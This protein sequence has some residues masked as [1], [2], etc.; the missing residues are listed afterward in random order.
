VWAINELVKGAL[1]CEQSRPRF[2]YIAPLYR[3]S[4]AIAWDY[5]LHYT[6]PIPGREINQAELRVD[7]PNGSRIQLFGAD[8]PDSLRGM[9]LDG[10][11]LDEYAQMQGRAWT[12][13]IRPALSDRKGWAV[14]IGTPQG[15]NAF[16]ELY[17]TA[18]GLPD[19]YVATYPASQTDILDPAELEAARR[20]MSEAEYAQEYECSWQAAIRGA[21]YGSLIEQAEADGRIGEVPHDP[22]IRVETWWDLGV[23]DSTAIW[24]AQRAGNQIRLIDYYEMTG[25][26]LDH[27]ARVLDERKYLYSRHIAP[28]DIMVRELGSGLTRL[29]VGGKLGIRFE[30][31]PKAP[32]DDGISAVR[33]ILPRCWFDRRKCSR[34]LDALRQYRSEYDDRLKAFRRKPLHDWTSHAA[35]AMRYG[36]VMPEA[37]PGEPEYEYEPAMAVGW[38]R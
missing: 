8:S 34:G 11:V 15:H 5:L 14:F 31:A 24:F 4:K 1:T 35:D 27:Y 30:V 10:V 7:L 21:Y 16:F 32:V 3:Q 20:E 37:A 17:E 6:Q 29:E 28:H 23:G 13:V 12:E 26:G 22:T 2:A 9:Y 38:M 18:R 19:W 36:A 25:V 33:S